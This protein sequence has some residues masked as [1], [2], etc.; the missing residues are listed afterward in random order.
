MKRRITAKPKKLFI[1]SSGPY[2]Y[3]KI[4]LAFDKTTAVF[5][6]DGFYGRYV[7][8]KWENLKSK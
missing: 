8:G 6:V 1:V 5:S 2:D 4:P 7:K 3:Q